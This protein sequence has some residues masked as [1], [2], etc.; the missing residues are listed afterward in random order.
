ME[1]GSGPVNRSK[2]VPFLCTTRRALSI[3]LSAGSSIP[4]DQEPDRGPNL[5][6]DVLPILMVKI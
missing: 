2:I 5:A 4:S 1:K 6:H 3:A